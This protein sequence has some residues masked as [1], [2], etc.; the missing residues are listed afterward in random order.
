MPSNRTIRTRQRRQALIATLRA[1][2]LTCGHGGPL[3]LDCVEPTGHWHHVTG[4]ESRVKFYEGQA[5]VG[6]LRGLCPNCHRAKSRQDFIDGK[7]MNPR[8]QDSHVRLY[9]KTWVKFEG[10]ADT[11]PYG[12]QMCEADRETMRR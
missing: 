7:R 5:K 1:S 3:E 6:N 10:I 9:W 4:S 12:Q 8:R 2:G 11:W